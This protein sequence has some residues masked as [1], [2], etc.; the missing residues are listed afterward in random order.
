MLIMSPELF[1]WRYSESFADQTYHFAAAFVIENVAYCY[2]VVMT[3]D[4]RKFTVDAI[5]F[6]EIQS[7]KRDM[8]MF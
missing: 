3:Y 2:D 6:R 5:L 8:L 4:V 7:K 1:A